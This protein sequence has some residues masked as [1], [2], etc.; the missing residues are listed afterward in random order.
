MIVPLMS[1]VSGI[2]RKRKQGDA[3]LL[4][5]LNVIATKGETRPLDIAA[6]LGVHQST[7]TRHL[8]NLE[9]QGK[10]NVTADTADRRSCKASLTKSG[11]EEL[12]RLGETGIARFEKMVAGWSAEEVKMLGG[13]LKKLEDSRTA[14]AASEAEAKPTSWRAK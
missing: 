9:K 11:L 14:M 12:Q 1:I 3:A 10:V 8:Q 13:L 6:E 2:D 7:V 4:S 5:V